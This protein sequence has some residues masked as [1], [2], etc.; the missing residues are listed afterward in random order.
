MKNNLLYGAIAIMSWLILYCAIDLYTSGA[1][2]RVIESLD[3][4][5]N[6]SMTGLPSKPVGEI[7]GE[8][9]AAVTPDTSS[10]S[11]KY[12]SKAP[13][14]EDPLSKLNAANIKRLTSRMSEL[15]KIKNATDS[16]SAAIEILMNASK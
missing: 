2:E 9:Y 11:I 8:Q 1:T 6:P 5:T 16:N 14:L 7:T 13:Q 3:S 15:D 4:A 10:N 12:N